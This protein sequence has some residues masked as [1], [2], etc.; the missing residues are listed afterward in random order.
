MLTH[1]D[2]IN[3]EIYN[4]LTK[5]SLIKLNCVNL[6]FKNYKPLLI[7]CNQF[8]CQIK[9]QFNYN[10]SIDPITNKRIKPHCKRY[11]I[12]QLLFNLKDKYTISP[13]TNKQIIIGGSIYLKVIE[14]YDETY[15][16]SERQYNNELNECIHYFN[17]KRRGCQFKCTR[18]NLKYNKL[19]KKCTQKYDK[20]HDFVY[21]NNDN[22]CIHCHEL[23]HVNC[24][25]YFKSY[26]NINYKY[27]SYCIY[28]GVNKY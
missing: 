1:I 15:L 6:Q 13:E 28:C 9:N 21:N 2:D 4:Y 26:V 24:Q 20:E 8:Y 14:K 19:Y 25:H 11:K 3:L 12:L 16:L 10:P 17:Y 18:C 7:L 27:K 5:I 22:K 23:Y